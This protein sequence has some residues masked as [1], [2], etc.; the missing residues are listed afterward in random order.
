MKN[1]DYLLFPETIS[2]YQLSIKEK[3]LEN[4]INKLNFIKTIE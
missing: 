4:F 1:T 2:V 3:T